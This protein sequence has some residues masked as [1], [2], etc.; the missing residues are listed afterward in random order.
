MARRPPGLFGSYVNRGLVLD[1][2]QRPA[3]EAPRGECESSSPSSKAVL[4][5]RAGIDQT[6]AIIP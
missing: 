1:V 4:L 3:R 5:S 2:D 6:T